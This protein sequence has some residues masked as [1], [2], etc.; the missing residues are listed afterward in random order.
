MKTF[1]LKTL[2]PA[3]FCRFE[4]FMIKILSRFKLL[5]YIYV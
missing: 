5:K 3:L 4:V 2:T 1:K